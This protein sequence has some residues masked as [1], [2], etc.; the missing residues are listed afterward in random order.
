MRLS[1]LLFSFLFLSATLWAQ[2][3]DIEIF[4]KKEGNKNIVMAR[5]IGKVSYKVTLTIEAEGMIVSPGIVVEG[6]VPAGY[7]KELATLEPQPGVSWSYGYEVSFIEYKGQP[8]TTGDKGAKSDL[9]QI[10]QS[11]AEVP[12]P[13]VLATELSTAPIMVYT[14]EGCGRCSFVKKELSKKQIEFEEVDVNSGSPEADN[15][16]KLLRDSGFTGS[17][18]T[19]PVVKINGELHYNIKDLSGFI[20]EIKL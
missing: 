6:I 18:V 16:W 15:M 20:E 1:I 4:E 12:I 17:T 7:M 14:R 2:G 13:P 9:N 5:N 10:S 3:N 8:T 11:A 19:M